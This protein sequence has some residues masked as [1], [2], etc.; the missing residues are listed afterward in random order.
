[1]LMEKN[2]LCY[3]PFSEKFE[4]F[5]NDVKKYS[6]DVDI[7]TTADYKLLYEGFLNECIQLNDMFYKEVI[8]FINTTCITV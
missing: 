1:M 6:N 3:K 8:D 2:I 7:H 5:K 4:F